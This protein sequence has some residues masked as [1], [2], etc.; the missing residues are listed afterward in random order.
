MAG[1]EERAREVEVDSH[2]RLVTDR[3]VADLEHGA[4]QET[5][6][7]RPRPAVPPYNPK[8]PPP[9]SSR[10][11]CGR[12]A[13]PGGAQ[14]DRLLSDRLARIVRDSRKRDPLLAELDPDPVQEPD[15]WCNGSPGPGGQIRFERAIPGFEG[16]YGLRQVACL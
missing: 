13:S 10:T 12:P 2:Y 6:A 5:L 15:G 8:A 7:R 14:C 3:V 16:I 1:K 4:D 11:G 9:S